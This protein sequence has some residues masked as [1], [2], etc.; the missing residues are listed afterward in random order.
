VRTVGDV[1]PKIHTEREATLELFRSLTPEQW[2]TASLC[3]GW[4]NREVAGH[5]LATIEMTPPKFF[6]GMAKSGFS[7]NKMTDRDAR[8]FGSGDLAAKLSADLKRTSHPPGPVEAMLGEAIVHAEDIRRPLGMARNYPEASLVG[9]ADFYKKSNL[10]VGA[11]KRIAGLRLQATDAQ[12][13][14]GD[15]PS[16]EGPLV[17]LI[18]AMTGRKSVMGDLSGEGV[19]TLSAR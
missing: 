5:M 12:W 8:A 19:A 10:I 1:W 14:N 16:V 6:A 4:S 2:A 17:S 9:V 11:K 13:S 15:G 7:F 18:M 3:E